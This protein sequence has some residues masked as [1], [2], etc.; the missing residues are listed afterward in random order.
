MLVSPVHG[1]DVKDTPGLQVLKV[2]VRVSELL[3]T[4][5]ETASQVA[6][7]CL[8]HL[9]RVVVVTLRRIVSVHLS[10]YLMINY[11]TSSPI[12]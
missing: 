7:R 3:L 1:A 4:L 12:L 5:L 10:F 6:I 11:E 2:H 8:F 9:F